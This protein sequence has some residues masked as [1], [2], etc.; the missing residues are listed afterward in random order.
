VLAAENGDYAEAVRQAKIALGIFET[1]GL[2]ERSAFAATVLGSALRYLGDREASRRC[3]QAAM[4]LRTQL[5]DRRGVSV[6]MNNLA[7]LALDDGDLAGAREQFAA[8]LVLK[9]LLG[10]NHSL[11][12]GLANL[13]DVLIRMGEL[14]AA[15]RALSEAS[16]LAA[17]I[18]NPQLIGILAANHGDLA[19]RQQ[20]WAEA[21]AH[22]QASVL[23]HREGGHA[24][25]VV[26]ALIGLGRATYWLGHPDE[27]IRHLRTAEAMAT[28]IAHPQGLADVRAALAEIGESA[29]AGPLPDGLTT[30][31]VEVLRLLAAGLSNK[32]IAGELHLSP[33][34][35]E[36]HLATVYRKLSLGGRVE[37][38]SY[39]V[40]H[41]IAAPAR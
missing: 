10:D 18:G 36:R 2:R 17:D 12:L 20:R 15:Q 35:V 5:G 33:V 6:A 41:G 7:L 9:R 29:T 16:E 22:Y 37:A 34:T 39:A 21:A 13:A 27:A 24:H 1:L 25:D 40:S 4:D 30:R 8:A 19:A 38:A 32:Q 14:D 26:V 31:Q 28:Q 3:F 23:A 11:A